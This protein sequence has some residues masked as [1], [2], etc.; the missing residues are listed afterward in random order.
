MLFMECIKGISLPCK[1]TQQPEMTDI[2]MFKL[3]EMLTQEQQKKTIND[4]V[5]ISTRKSAKFS[6]GTPSKRRAKTTV[7][8]KLRNI[9][10]QNCTVA[11]INQLLTNVRSGRMTID[12]FERSHQQ[13]LVR[14]PATEPE[15]N[16]DSEELAVGRS[17]VGM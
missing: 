6:R 14:Q 4:L 12:E 16:W 10:L 8:V 17:V 5:H 3:A 11:N 15:M 13:E 2:N 9:I 1:T 7:P